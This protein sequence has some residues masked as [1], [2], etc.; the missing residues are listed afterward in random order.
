MKL[1]VG[2]IFLSPPSLQTLHNALSQPSTSNP[3]DLP[4]VV[5]LDDDEYIIGGISYELDGDY[6]ELRLCKS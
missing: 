1:S 6:V 3:L 4:V 2:T 5:K